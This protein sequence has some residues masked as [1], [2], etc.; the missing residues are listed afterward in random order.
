MVVDVGV[1]PS[2]DSTPDELARWWL[3]TGQHLS[4]ELWRVRDRLIDHQVQHGDLPGLGVTF[5]YEW[6]PEAANEFPDLVRARSVAV[7]DLTE[8]DF[9]RLVELVV[10]QVP[11]A[12]VTT[13]QKIDGRKANQVILRGGTDGARLQELRAGKPRL[14][15]K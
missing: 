3:D 5:Y 14:V 1:I 13:G 9:Q 7:D 15:V 11:S 12:K 4:A 10:E 2:L 8:P 6:N